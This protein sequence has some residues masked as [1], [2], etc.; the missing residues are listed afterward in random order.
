MSGFRLRGTLRRTAVAL[1]EA[2]SRTTIGASQ[3]RTTER[4]LIVATGCLMFLATALPDAADDGPTLYKQ[5][6]AT[7]HDTGLG[8]A[9]TRDRK[10][11]GVAPST[12]SD[13]APG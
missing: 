4:S 12:M 10:A 1:A 2:V 3:M 9:P 6:C 5:L 7:C 13:P 11:R 8:R